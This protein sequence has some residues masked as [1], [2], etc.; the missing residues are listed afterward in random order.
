MVDLL[1]AV[2]PAFE[3]LHPSKL[4]D[5]FLALQKVMECV[6]HFNGGMD[7][8]IQQLKK[9]VRR[10]AGNEVSTISCDRAIFRKP[11]NFFNS[12]YQI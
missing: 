7:Y 1:K 4:G 10:C 11:Q 2:E 12:E 6:L 9:Q 5:T 3:E 8:K